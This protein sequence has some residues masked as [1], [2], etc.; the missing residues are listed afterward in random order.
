MEIKKIILMLSIIIAIIVPWYIK[1]TPHFFKKSKCNKNNSLIQMNDNLNKLNIC[2]N[3]EFDVLLKIL[4]QN[5]PDLRFIHLL[6]KEEQYKIYSQL[7]ENYVIDAYA[8][9]EY[10]NQKNIDLQEEFI[11]DRD[12][13][14]KIMENNFNMTMFQKNIS[15]EIKIDDTLAKEYYEANKNILFASAPFTKI[16]PG[17]NAHAIIIDNERKSDKEYEK[18][19]LDKKNCIPI[20]NYNPQIMQASNS[21]LSDALMSMKIKEYRKITLENGQKIMLYKLSENKGEWLA[22]DLISEKV[23]LVLKKKLIEDE[24]SKRILDLKN[25]FN[26]KVSQKNLEDYIEGKMLF[27]KNQYTPSDISDNKILN[28]EPVDLDLQNTELIEE[29][30]IKNVEQESVK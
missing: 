7:L 13:Y 14:L 10:L 12:L 28:L 21:L 24:Y 17:I 26:I 5:S 22:Y 18:M 4:S 9:K 29:Q 3:E 25:K 6:S 27:L 11:K 23:K 15:D 1:Y 19:L 8:V 16:I 2:N 30:M 20:E